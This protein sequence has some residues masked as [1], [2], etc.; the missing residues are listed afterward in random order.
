MIQEVAQSHKQVNTVIADEQF[1]KLDNAIYPLVHVVPGVWRIN[2]SKL[3]QRFLLVILDLCSEDGSNRMDA[4]SDTQL[5]GADIVA[6]LQDKQ[7]EQGLEIT[8]YGEAS[9]IVDGE[10]DV[11]SGWIVE[12]LV[13]QDYEQNTCFVPLDTP[14]Q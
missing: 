13:A 1:E 8:M 12:L 6:V 4:L 9:K 14:E 10:G 5:V 3:S 11:A 7:D 2:N